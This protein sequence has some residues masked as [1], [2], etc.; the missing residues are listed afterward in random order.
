MHFQQVSTWPPTEVQEALTN[1]LKYSGLA[2]TEVNL[3]FREHELK[4]EV[5]DQGLSQTPG[6]DIALGRGLIGMQERVTAYGG[7]LEAGP[8]LERGYAVRAWLPLN[9][10]TS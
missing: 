1:C 10:V 2:C 4:L 6:T 8:C 9:L 7:K 3:D 5:V